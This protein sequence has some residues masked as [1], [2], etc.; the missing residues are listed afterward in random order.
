MNIEEDFDYGPLKGLIGTWKGDK[1]MDVSP[2][3]DGEERSPYYEE[4]HFEAAGDVDNAETQ[5]LTILRYHQKVFRKKNDKQFHDQVGYLTWDADAKTVTHTYAIPR[6]V[7]VVATGTAAEENGAVTLEFEARH[8][9]DGGIAE[10]QF[11][12]DNAATKRFQ[13]TMVIEG[14]SLRYTQ[15]M[16]LAIYGRTFKHTDESELS[17][18]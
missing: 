17:R 11:M 15:T 1:G 14:D 6:G 18:S 16:V 4:W 8:N 9:G 12:Q 10:T 2:E 13:Q 7:S 5:V 3:P